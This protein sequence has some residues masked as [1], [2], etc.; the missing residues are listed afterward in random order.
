[1]CQIT[2]SENPTLSAGVHG[3][4]RRL[5]C[6][7]KILRGAVHTRR[8]ALKKFVLVCVENLP[9][10]T[11][12]TRTDFVCVGDTPERVG[13]K[14]GQKNKPDSR[15]SRAYLFLFMPLLYSL[16]HLRVEQLPILTFVIRWSLGL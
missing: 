5:V 9:L 10:G 3:W 4:A 16:Q 2:L 14:S 15:R 12:N 11:L 1:V 13:R 8:V 7:E 6:V